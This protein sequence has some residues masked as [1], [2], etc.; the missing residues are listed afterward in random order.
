MRVDATSYQHAAEEILRWGS[1]RESRYVCVATV[2][3]VVVAYD[4][5]AYREV[6]DGYPRL[7]A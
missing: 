4:H 3:N 1:L 2:N 7:V 6:M 5:P